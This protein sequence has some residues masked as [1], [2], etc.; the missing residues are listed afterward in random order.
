VAGA[1]PDIDFGYAPDLRL[2]YAT[3]WNLTLER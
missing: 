2:P 3:H 1:S